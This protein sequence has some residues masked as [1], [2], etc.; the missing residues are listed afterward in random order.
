MRVTDT[1]SGWNPMNCSKKFEK[2]KTGGIGN[3][4]KKN[5][6]HPNYN[7]VKVGYNNVK[8]PGDLKGLAVT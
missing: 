2:K 1:S 6:D 8:S 3:Q 4:K 7:I 5:R